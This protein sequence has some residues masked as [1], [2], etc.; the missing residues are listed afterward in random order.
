M[1]SYSALIIDNVC[2]GLARPLFGASGTPLRGH[3]F[4]WSTLEGGEPN[5]YRDLPA[6]AADDVLASYVHVHW[7]SNPA[8]AESFVARCGSR[9]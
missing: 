3:Q 2:N 1:P 9:R 4:R 8:A 7:A 6:Y 5:A